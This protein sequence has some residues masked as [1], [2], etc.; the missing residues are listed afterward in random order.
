MARWCQNVGRRAQ[1]SLAQGFTV[2]A[3]GL[4]ASAIVVLALVA[5][6]WV[7]QLHRQSAE[8]LA[9]RDL[10]WHAARAADALVRIE[11]RL[12]EV[13]DSP[14]LQTALTDSNVRDGYLQPH[15][16]SMRALDGV[17]VRLALADF[18]GKPVA[19]QL[20]FKLS[21]M[22]RQWFEADVASR[23][24]RV[25]I[26]DVG[27]DQLMLL[28]LG[29]V[30]QRSN[31]VEGH[32]WAVLRLNDLP[33]DEAHRLKVRSTGAAAQGAKA[34]LLPL[35]PPLDALGLAMVRGEVKVPPL[36]SLHYAPIFLIV[37]A[38]L[39][40]GAGVAARWMARGLTRELAALERFA[41]QVTQVGTGG[42]HAPTVGPNE[43]SS[44]A[45]SINQMLDRLHEQHLA[46]Q[47]ES[48]RQ[49][50]LLA[51][52][53]DNLSDTVIIT[54][55]E[56]DG[57]AP[58][59]PIV[60]AN[61]AFERLT[62]YTVAEAL[63][64]SPSFLQGPDTDPAELR[65]VSEALRNRQAVRTELLNYTKSGST[66]WVEMEIVPVHDQ[67]GRAVHFVSIER[68]TT[69]RRTLEQQLRETQ[70]L[71][72]IGTLAGGI[73]HDFNNVLAAILGNVELSRIDLGKGHSIDQ[74]LRQIAQSAERGRALV[75]QILA[76]SRRQT[77]QRQPQE[78]GALISETVAMLR[79]TV[80]AGVSITTQL[81]AEPVIVIGEATSIEQVLLNF[82]TNAWQAL[83]EPG[84][85]ITFGL[86]VEHPRDASPLAHIWVSDN[87]CGMDEATLRRVFE[88]FFTTKPVGRGTGLGLAV[89]D[90]IVRQHGGRI[91]VDSRPN[92]GSTFHVRLPL[93]EHTLP[94]VPTTQDADAPASP[95]HLR[96]LYVDDDEVLTV[97]TSALLERWGCNVTTTNSA[98]Q[99]MSALREAAK[100]F[101]VVV[102]DVNM[103]GW[104][105]LDLAHEV[106]A[107]R[108][109]LP[110]ILTSGYVTEDLQRAA[111]A[112]G[113]RALIRKERLCD[114]LVAV[115]RPIA[116][117]GAIAQ[118]S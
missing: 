57:K 51:T 108:P 93:S 97:V 83:T 3:A 27:G 62:G 81:P 60:Y 80:P 106:G 76:Y 43:V 16:E 75:Q 84:G 19:R 11:T 49:L 99:A 52:C 22:E 18:A 70:K 20:S 89:V 101:D 28:S 59:L 50:T 109:D 113:V 38:L 110:V 118:S 104:S 31:T 94:S 39:V 33:Q 85:Q 40:V 78:L 53:I 41:H 117:R 14:L 91:T 114:D 111:H 45:G 86:E 42:V 79:A 13:A 95:L 112:A 35:P 58:G 44:L 36:R 8:Q 5:W 115:L 63:G 102:S 67:S 74:W 105:G 6:I 71:E 23:G 98:S 47:T 7:D 88:P 1:G 46:L 48:Q 30:Y 34:V 61:P 64:R 82:G 69:A 72:A 56:P 37:A 92:E 29:V 55:I 12:R 25:A 100:D 77:M 66:Y 107:V 32:L 17:P 24:T 4:T 87:G 116:E 21:E 26:A 96:V 10:Q 68:D 54:D 73:A 2:A 9:D 65:R 103:P 90:G 15:L